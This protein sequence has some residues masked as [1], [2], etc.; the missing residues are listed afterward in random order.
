MPQLGLGLGLHKGN[1]IQSA[2]QQ[3]I[4]SSDFY[5]DP[6]KADGQPWEKLEPRTLPNGV[7]NSDYLQNV[8]ADVVFNGSEDWQPYADTQT[9]VL[10]FY[11]SNATPN[12]DVST[13]TNYVIDGYFSNLKTIVDIGFG[14]ALVVNYEAFYREKSIIKLSIAKTKV[15]NL[16]TFKAWLASNPITIRYQLAA[17]IDTLNSPFTN[18]WVDLSGVVGKNLF[19]VMRPFNEITTNTTLNFSGNGFIVA[20]SVAGLFKNAEYVVQLAPL[21]RYTL[22][23]TS[24][25]TGTTGGGVTIHSSPSG[26]NQIS[27]GS[28]TLNGVWTFTTTATGL[29][30]FRYQCTGG[31]S[32]V[33]SA[34]FTNIQLE[35]GSVATA[36]E[37]YGKANCL[38]NGFAGTTASG[39]GLFPVKGVG[40]DIPYTNLVINS[41]FSQGTTGWGFGN[42]SLTGTTS[43]SSNTLTHTCN[44]GFGFGYSLQSKSLD[45]NKRYYAIT[46][47]RVTN[48]NC[49]SLQLLI[50]SAN[51]VSKES[52][53]QNI[54]Y[55]MSGI[56]NVV[57][58]DNI[59]YLRHQYADA[60]IA[61]G[62]VAEFQQVQLINLDDNP[63]VQALEAKLGRQ[64]TVA[65]CDLLFSF[66]ATSATVKAKGVPFL[67]LDST[68]DFG[69]FANMDVLNPVG[70]D[71]FAQMVVLRPDDTTA[72][73][74]Y[75]ISRNDTSEANAQYSIRFSS[76][77]SMYYTINGVIRTVSLSS[78][79]LKYVLFGRINNTR[80]ANV[81]G[82]EVD[83]FSYPTAITTRLNT[84]LGCRSDSLDGLTKTAFYD[85]LQ[86]DIAFW[87]GPQGTLDKTKIVSLV[88]KAMKS[89]YGLGV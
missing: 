10:G 18:P 63:Q 29:I 72:T 83:S 60:T 56:L 32:E 47:A 26:A 44:G 80:F 15:S 77:G 25:R 59:I 20:S 62:K 86:G 17:P 28:S 30:Y 33:A 71:D 87:K 37:P 14:G 78:T 7:S 41:D 39:Y 52:P 3:L 36:Y 68:N 42:S 69:Q 19:D 13:S 61:N 57:S 27:G 70:T 40:D 6:N 9:D 55:A 76:D 11:I 43:V 53:V 81:N 65:E 82:I 74:F 21:T 73:R 58:F 89:K 49:Q 35:L 1:L 38:L 2:Q 4:R 85:G 23:Y 24:T 16:S 88:S 54:W 45:L 5:L 8:S 34:T 79:D 46:K 51:T 12:S 22:K 48:S 84:Q 66:T 75:G 67:N 31:T 64:L 50:G